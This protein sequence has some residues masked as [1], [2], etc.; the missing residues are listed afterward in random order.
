LVKQLDRYILDPF[1]PEVRAKTLL[2]AK[3]PFTQEAISFANN[4]IRNAPAT[5]SLSLYNP[6]GAF[7]LVIHW[8]RSVV[9]ADRLNW[10]SMEV[11]PT[12][13]LGEADLSRNLV[14]SLDATNNLVNVCPLTESLLA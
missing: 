11:P 14:L 10:V 1:T 4:F 12:V 3:K 7:V 5:Y 6:D 13:S 8:L 2:W 9:L